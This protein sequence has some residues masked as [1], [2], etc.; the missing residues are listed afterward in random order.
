MDEICR[1]W[2][3]CAGIDMTFVMLSQ[4]F[5]AG[6]IPCVLDNCLYRAKY[7][8]IDEIVALRDLNDYR[9]R[10]CFAFGQE[11][12]NSIPE[13]YTALVSCADAD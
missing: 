5:N 12:K 7:A 3:P 4:I 10:I 13:I 11:K 8:A 1:R 6:V 9:F 2:N